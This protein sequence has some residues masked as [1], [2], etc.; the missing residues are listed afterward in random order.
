MAAIDI[1]VV[2]YR[3][4]ALTL[5]AV[6]RLLPW[7]TGCIHVVDNSEDPAEARALAQ[8]LGL[9]LGL[10]STAS[11]GR[12][13]AGGLA[14]HVM[15]RNVGF[16]AGCNHAWQRSNA[17]WVLLLNPDTHF[18]AAAA[19]ALAQVL[20]QHPRWAAASPRTWWDRIGGFLLPLPA[21][22]DPWSR[23]VRSWG[24]RWRPQAWA[25]RAAIE[26]LQAFDGHS[27][28]ELPCLAGAVLML[29][30]QA[31]EEAGGLF[32][33]RY[34]MYFEDTDLS[35][36]LRRSGWQLGM[37]ASCDAVHSWQHQPHKAPLMASAEKS[38]LQKHYPVFGML[39]QRWPGV[40]HGGQLGA[41]RAQWASVEQAR[42]HLGAVR[43]W[44]PSATGDPAIVRKDLGA[45]P[46][47]PHEWDLLAPGIYWAWADEGWVG[48]EKV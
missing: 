35:L 34:F 44:S 37:T 26:A 3:S 18:E 33:E 23:C 19:L 47:A 15:P 46:F 14:L 38:F 45:A 2:N 32:D 36:R 27:E 16:A 13:E 7:P 48:F 8:G 11:V 28:I 12:V 17:P 21:A 41:A 20:Q 39:K 25:S 29:R 4:A 43:A 31:V 30:R 6:S 42:Q 9:S 10:G 40:L 5:Q 22:Q 1:I 24:S